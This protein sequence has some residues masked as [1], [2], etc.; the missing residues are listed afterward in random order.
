MVSTRW[1]TVTEA[2][3]KLALE[4]WNTRSDFVLQMVI[5]YIFLL[6]PPPA[7]FVQL[8]SEYKNFFF[9]LLIK[10][11][12]LTI[13]DGPLSCIFCCYC[14]VSSWISALFPKRNASLTS[15]LLSLFRILTPYMLKHSNY[16]HLRHV[17]IDESAL[18]F[19]HRHLFTILVI[20]SEP[21][22]VFS[23]VTPHLK[24]KETLYKDH[25][26]FSN[27]AILG[28]LYILPGQ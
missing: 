13:S 14:Y 6:W 25:V 7:Y 18:L 21:F 4:Y 2:G 11:V 8:V 1:L 12:T 16:F 22:E 17:P 26:T 23:N 20:T 15:S 9:L 24:A 27:R 3:Y 28:K 10:N 19:F 5:I